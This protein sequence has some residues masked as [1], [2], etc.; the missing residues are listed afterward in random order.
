MAENEVHKSESAS[1]EEKG[2]MT[3]RAGA[4]AFHPSGLLPDPDSHL[5]AKE[6]AAIVSI[7]DVRAQICTD[8]PFSGSQTRLETRLDF[9]PV[10]EQ[11]LTRYPALLHFADVG[12][13]A[14]HPLPPRLPRPNEHRKCQN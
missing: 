2:I 8:I 7:T 11:P 1:E 13:V 10:G 9:D 4:S 3:Q 12:L 5:S 6:R 14:L